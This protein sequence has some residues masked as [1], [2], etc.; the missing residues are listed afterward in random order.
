[1]QST[2]K[3]LFK[4]AHTE[5]HKFHRSLIDCFRHEVVIY[6]CKNN[7]LLVLATDQK[8]YAPRPKKKR[9]ESRRA[10]WKLKRNM[11]RESRISIKGNDRIAPRRRDRKWI[12]RTDSRILSEAYKDFCLSATASGICIYTY[13]K[14]LVLIPYAPLARHI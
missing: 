9:D 11:Q 5:F 7:T 2:R 8:T 12:E 13:R 1:M 10:I 14:Y 3:I 6:V 4:H